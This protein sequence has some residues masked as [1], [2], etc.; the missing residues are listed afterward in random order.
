[1]TL[2]GIISGPAATLD[3][4]EMSVS[5][6]A[7]LHSGSVRVKGII[8][9]I[10]KLKKIIKS[11]EYECQICC[12]IMRVAPSI[13]FEGQKHSRADERPNLYQPI[14]KGPSRCSNERCESNIKNDDKATRQPW[15]AVSRRE[16]VNAILIELR[17]IETFSDI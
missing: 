12:N 11:Q 16:Y 13:I 4:Y 10:S 8:S 3:N 14:S 5:Q 2:E 7:R 15:Y 1:M 9:G 17:D 6:A